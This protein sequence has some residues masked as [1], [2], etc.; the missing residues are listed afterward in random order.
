MRSSNILFSGRKHSQ[1]VQLGALQQTNFII[2]PGYAHLYAIGSCYLLPISIP[3][4]RHCCTALLEFGRVYQFEVAAY[5]G[6][7]LG[8]PAQLNVSTPE[9]VPDGYP[10]QVRLNGQSATA[11]E[12]TW[13]PPIQQQWNGGIVNYQ[14]RYFQSSS[15]NTTEVVRVTNEPRLI[16]ENLKER[17]FYTVLVRA[18]T[19]NGPGPWSLPSTIQTTAECKPPIIVF[20]ICHKHLV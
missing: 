9:N 18:M 13:S 7:D 5:N 14:V 6:V 3:V 4:Y 1:L 15:P 16:I 11:V 12:V 20:T 19:N 8:L 17:T 10:L 2:E